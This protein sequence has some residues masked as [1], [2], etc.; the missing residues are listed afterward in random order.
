MLVTL[1]PTSSAE[2]AATAPA[3]AL[4]TRLRLPQGLVGFPESTSAELIE[5]PEAPP[6]SWLRLEGEAPVAF[7]VMEPTGFIAD[8]Q[9]ELFDEDAAALGLT[10]GAQAAVLNIV[11]VGPDATA[12]TVNLTGPI[13]VNRATGVA[14][15]VVLANHA[16]YS[17]RHP[18]G[19][20]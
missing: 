11:T 19:G 15:Q 8:Y 1:E 17:V 5:A 10:E 12:A 3:A 20:S 14:K 6:F 9:L 18:L 13:V 4:P 2:R 7:V 16:R